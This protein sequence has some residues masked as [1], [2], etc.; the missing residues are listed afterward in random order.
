MINILRYN[1]NTS[2]YLRYVHFLGNLDMII[3][4]LGTP[5]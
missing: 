4:H 3:I 5:I 1:Y 2:R